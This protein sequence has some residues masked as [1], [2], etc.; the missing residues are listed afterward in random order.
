MIFKR[1][2]NTDACAEASVIR[3]WIFQIR[4]APKKVAVDPRRFAQY[5]SQ[6]AANS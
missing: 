5:V 1:D 6:L 4:A 2:A 3:P